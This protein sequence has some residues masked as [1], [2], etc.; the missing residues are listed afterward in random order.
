MPDKAEQLVKLAEAE[1]R[2]R[3]AYGPDFELTEAEKRMLRAAA[4]GLIADCTL[5]GPGDPATAETWPRERTIRPAVLRWSCMEAEPRRRIDPKGLQIYAARMDGAIDLSFLELCWPLA[6]V[7]CALRGGV[8][9]VRASTRDVKFSCCRLGLLAET[10]PSV[11]EGQ[12]ISLLGD[13]IT[14]SGGLFLDRGL[15]A[16]GEVRLV[17]GNITGDL[18]CRGAAILNGNGFS[19]NAGGAEIRGSVFLD[20][21]GGDRDSSF[22]C[23]GAVCLAGAKIGQD[24]SCNSPMPTGEGSFVL[25]MQRAKVGGVLSLKGDFH[26]VGLVD[27]RDA[28]SNVLDDHPTSWPEPGY[29]RIDGFVYKRIGPDGP[30]DAR[31]RIDWLS[32]QYPPLPARPA[33]APL[34]WATR[35]AAPSPAQPRC[36]SGWASWKGI[37]AAVLRQTA[38]VLRG[39]LAWWK[40]RRHSIAESGRRNLFRPQPYTQL[41]KVLRDSGHLADAREI[42]ITRERHRRTYGGMNFFARPFHCL[43][44][45]AVAYGYRWWQA[46]AWL[47]VFVALGTSIF[48]LGRQNG[49]MVPS[50][51]RVYMSQEYKRDH[52]LPAEYPRFNSFVY[53]FDT[54][55]PVVDLHQEA[56]WRP[57]TTDPW[58]RKLRVYLWCHVIFG[59]ALTAALVAGLARALRKEG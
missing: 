5:G 19:L 9:L 42:L 46:F 37:A 16:E 15:V 2:S 30:T 22:R 43:F 18:A 48:H 4:A 31:S 21:A 56:Y 45:L 20:A 39:Q 24:L 52:L 35:A 34:T 25:V 29:L 28:E 58:G 40:D 41:A 1:L 54:F 8:V 13:G 36:G 17:N 32:R 23:R 3:E 27:V 55:V 51:E 11:A 57:L 12:T 33:I 10:H 38:A 49:L 59:W 47:L 44:G 50:R 53:A 14:I 26:S 6:M 7:S